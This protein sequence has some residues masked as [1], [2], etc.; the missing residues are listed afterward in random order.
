M[1]AA[2]LFVV[3][4]VAGYT[5][6]YKKI[7]PQLDCLFSKNKQGV[8]FDT[9]SS[10]DQVMMRR[11]NGSC[12]CDTIIFIKSETNQSYSRSRREA[13]EKAYQEQQKK[14]ELP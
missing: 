12:I 10:G 14:H 7:S 4:I 3:F 9:T 8:Y 5:G 6:M 11:F 2:F 1:A 13:A